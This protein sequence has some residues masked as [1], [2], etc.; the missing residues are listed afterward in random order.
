MWLAPS[1]WADQVRAAL[2]HHLRDRHPP[3]AAV[4]AAA[5]RPLPE[6][7]ER[8]NP[9]ERHVL[10]HLLCYWEPNH[11]HQVD[12]ADWWLPDP[13][14][15]QAHDWLEGELAALVHRPATTGRRKTNQQRVRSRLG[16][17]VRQ[18]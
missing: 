14:R 1:V 7:W 13:H 5:P 17:L 2:L 8:A 9:W 18:L 15:Q 10:L 6:V 4:V 11:P 12:L 16:L 3:A